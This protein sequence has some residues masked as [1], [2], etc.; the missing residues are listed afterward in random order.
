MRIMDCV[1]LL[2]QKRVDSL[3]LDPDKP[4]PKPSW[5]ESLKLMSQSSFLTGLQNFPKDSINEEMVELMK[6]YFEMED[7]NLETAKKVSMY[8]DI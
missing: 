2:F 7:Y 5:G 3:A 8:I 4:G 1:L 6:P